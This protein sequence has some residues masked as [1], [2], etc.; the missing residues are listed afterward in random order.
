MADFAGTSVTPQIRDLMTAH[1][2]GGVTL[3]Q[4]NVEHP[5]QVAALCRDLQQAAAAAGLP[6]LL[7]AIDQ[8]GGS[9]ERLPLG[10]PGAMALGATRSAALAEQAGA[11]TGRALSA[12]GVNVNF[13][14][15][16]DVNTN[17]ANPV[18]GT[19]SFGDDPA[20]V[21]ALGRAY[22]RG[23]QRH[24]L[25]AT[26][27]HFPGHGDTEVDSH[28]D[29]PVV[30]HA[31]ERLGAVEFAPFREVSG[32]VAAIM[33]AHVAVATMGMTPATL[34]PALLE[35]ILR[36]EWGF[37]GIIF[38][39]SLAMAAIADHVGAGRAAVLALL[40]GADVL[41]ALGG[42]SILGEVFTAVRR[43]VADGIVSVERL[44]QSVRRIERVRAAMAPPVGSDPSPRGA[45]G[46]ELQ[47]F[48]R[49]VASTAVT[50][51]RNETGAVPLRGG[52]IHIIT[53][54]PRDAT[55]PTL[56]S[57]LRGWRPDVAEIVVDP[58]GREQVEVSPD[59]PTVLVTHSRG[60]P[61]PLQ[62]EFVRRVHR[63]AGNRLIVVAT[64]TPYDLAA[65][66][67]VP[68]YVATYGREPVMLEAAARLL[69]GESAPRGRL[70]VSIPGCH[71][72]GWGVVW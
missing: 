45:T 39:D 48:A 2:L 51:V 14:P 60:R 1:A 21:G 12:A 7:V 71:P 31:L 55:G 54:R 42:E 32:E 63:D 68:S 8:E 43:A 66:P 46:S 16:L 70:P 53:V 19:R 44:E 3:F 20:L 17:P 61:D 11:L 41:L 67:E 23:L 35:G 6:P 62:S 52:R 27:K 13:A 24:G 40:A 34:S 57:A 33:T 58:A 36:R 9:V 72:G 5:A 65:F 15:V 64:G 38:T 50:L 47:Q 59:E 30:P 49:E 25:M 10:M 18:I 29:L 26:A 28:L 22:V 69:A 37:G 56:G 4:K